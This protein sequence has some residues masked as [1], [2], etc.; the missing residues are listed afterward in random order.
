MQSVRPPGRIQAGQELKNGLSEDLSCFQI[1]EHLDALFSGALMLET[2]HQITKR[3][4]FKHLE[5][6]GHCCRAFDVRV[7]YR[8]VPGKGIF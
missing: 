8:A 5:S 7:R 2:V 6:C 3:C 1:R 4:L